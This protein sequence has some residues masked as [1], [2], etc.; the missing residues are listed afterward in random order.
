MFIQHILQVRNLPINVR[1]QPTL[2]PRKWDSTPLDRQRVMRAMAG[3]MAVRQA[4]QHMRVVW[5]KLRCSST[6]ER[7]AGP[8]QV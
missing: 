2:H 6:S 7:V 1:G 4:M 5:K 8:P 3:P